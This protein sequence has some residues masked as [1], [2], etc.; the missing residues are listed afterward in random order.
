M[1]PRDFWDSFLIPSK[2]WMLL[3]FSLFCFVFQ[4]LLGKSYNKGT[5]SMLPICHLMKI[6]ENIIIL[7]YIS[8]SQCLVNNIKGKCSK[9]DQKV[10]DI[11]QIERAV[12][13]PGHV[14]LTFGNRSK[15]HK[16]TSFALIWHC[17]LYIAKN[18]ILGFRI[19]KNGTFCNMFS[20]GD[21]LAFLTTK[22]QT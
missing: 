3:F 4:I 11:C 2:I 8:I 20:N 22:F 7:A 5:F 1:I 9:F 6:L 18:D 19:V 17:N 15:F 10:C 12:H 21:V 14:T 16:R 13:H